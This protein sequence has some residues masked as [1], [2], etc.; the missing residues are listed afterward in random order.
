MIYLELMKKEVLTLH[1]NFVGNYNKQ[2]IIDLGAGGDQPFIRR[3]GGVIGEIYAAPYV[4]VNPANGNLL[5]EDINGNITEDIT[6]TDQ[7]ATGKK[8]LPRLPR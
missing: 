1:L 6:D 5:F 2:E 8:H 4:G 3:V 7:R